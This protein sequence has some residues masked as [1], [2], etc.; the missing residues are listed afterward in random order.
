MQNDNFESKA[1]GRGEGCTLKKNNQISRGIDLSKLVNSLKVACERVVK[2]AWL[3]YKIHNFRDYEKLK[4]V[5]NCWRNAGVAVELKY[6]NNKPQQ[7][8]QNS[9][10]ET[11]TYRVISGTHVTS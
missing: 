11:T 6:E 4:K 9:C 3:I 8:Q 1:E 2:L 10:P 7:Q 5:Y